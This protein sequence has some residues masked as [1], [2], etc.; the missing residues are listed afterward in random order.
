MRLLKFIATSFKSEPTLSLLV[1]PLLVLTLSLGVWQLNRADYKRQ[2]LDELAAPPL[3]IASADA[4]PAAGRTQAVLNGRFIQ[5]RD[6]LLDNS[7]RA[8]IPGLAVVS[9]FVLRDGGAVLV[10]RGWLPAVGRRSDYA[11]T[12][13]SLPSEKADFSHGLPVELA[14]LYSPLASA[15]ATAGWPKFVVRLDTE[16]ISAWLQQPLS[17]Q[18]AW[19]L[20]EI[21]S[22]PLPPRPSQGFSPARHLGYAAQW[23]ALA[24][25][26]LIGY[27]WRVLAAARVQRRKA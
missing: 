7:P 20:E 23:F 1:P 22:L 21:G 13:P 17:P 8:G 15:E 6:L 26:L 5:G 16:Q 27:L 12:L 10:F 24:A 9:P 2:L 3:H 14:P 18:V 25:V 4:L 11:S 19:S